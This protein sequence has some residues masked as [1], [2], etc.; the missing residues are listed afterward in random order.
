MGIGGY[1]S[2]W[3]RQQCGSGHVRV[4]H[5]IGQSST[6]CYNP[7]RSGSRT[8]QQLVSLAASGTRQVVLIIALGM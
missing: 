6:S 2:E 5:G 4:A 3:Q 7:V 8:A 1:S